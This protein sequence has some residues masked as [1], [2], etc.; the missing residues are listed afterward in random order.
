MIRM[1]S[2]HCSLRWDPPPGMHQ[3]KDRPH[4]V[5]GT[6]RVLDIGILRLAPEE[7]LA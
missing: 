1:A 2:R 7:N 5:N 6:D 3:Q 4:T